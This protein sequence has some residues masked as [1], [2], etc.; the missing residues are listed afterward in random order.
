[1]ITTAAIT[2]PRCS[3]RFEA[4]ADRETTSRRRTLNGA[5]TRGVPVSTS[6]ERSEAE[7][8]PNV[9]QTFELEA[10]YDD[11]ADRETVTVHPADPEDPT[12]E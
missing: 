7:C 5:T 11:S 12:I 8:P 2:C 10:A 4:I 1:V 6:A 3:R 9:P